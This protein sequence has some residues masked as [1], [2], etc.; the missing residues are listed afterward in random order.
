MI[1]LTWPLSWQPDRGIHGLTSREGARRQQQTTSS[2]VGRWP[3]IT[4]D[5]EET[6]ER[7]GDPG[8]GSTR[9]EPRSTKEVHSTWVRA[10]S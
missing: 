2:T 9:N 7:A 3:W 4:E 5:V 10:Q 1:S 6:D 8:A